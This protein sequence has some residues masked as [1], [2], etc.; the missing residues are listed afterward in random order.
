MILTFFNYRFQTIFMSAGIVVQSL[1][2]Y[3]A[4]F[5][6]IFQTNL[7][8]IHSQFVSQQINNTFQSKCSLWVS[9]SS[10]RTCKHVI[11]I[12]CSCIKSACLQFIQRRKRLHNHKWSSGSPRSIRT[13]IFYNIYFS[14]CKISIL[15]NPSR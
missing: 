10:E 4:F 2:G 1:S 12:N 15:I 3:L 6:C 5:I 9:I 8:F 7:R 13:I 11:G 14:E